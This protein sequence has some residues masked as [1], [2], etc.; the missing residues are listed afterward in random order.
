MKSL[1]ENLY[2]PAEVDL[3][4]NCGHLMMAAGED[5]KDARAYEKAVTYYSRAFE[6]NSEDPDIITFLAIAY[7]KQNRLSDAE[8]V[9]NWGLFLYPS[10]PRLLW[11][12]TNLQEKIGLEIFLSK[13]D[14]AKANLYRKEHVERGQKILMGAQRRYEFIKRLVEEEE[15]PPGPDE[16]KAATHR[17]STVIVEGIEAL[18]QAHRIEKKN[19]K[20]SIELHLTHCHNTLATARGWY[21]QLIDLERR[22][23][24]RK[25]EEARRKREEEERER[26]KKEQQEQDEMRKRRARNERA[27][28]LTQQIANTALPEVSEKPRVPGELGPPLAPRGQKRPAEDPLGDARRS[29]QPRV[30]EGEGETMMDL[31][32]LEEDDELLQPD[33]AGDAEPREAEAAGDAEAG[34]NENPPPK[35]PEPGAETDGDLLGS[36]DD[37]F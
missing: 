35:D 28:N 25:R 26:E 1:Q 4:V 22:E 34:E 33:A 19:I 37:L 12:H 27:E 6:L 36:D 14:K 18:K 3:A 23:N 7:Y 29:A 15:H 31:F 10:D 30:G 2:E 17:T 9:L 24:E 11:N 16:D 21:E 32:G 20:E 5:V 13:D 8:R